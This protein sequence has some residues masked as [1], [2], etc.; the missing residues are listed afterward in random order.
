TF[1]QIAKPVGNDKHRLEVVYTINE[2][3]RVETA[4][5]VTV[6][7][8]STRQGLIDRTTQLRAG[9]PMR[10]DELLASESRLYNLGIFDWA[11]VD[12]RRQITTQNQEDVL[13]KLHEAKKNS[14]TYGFGFEV[15]N[16]GG[17]IPSGTV[18]L[19]NLPVVG[20]PANFKTSQQTFWGPRGTFEYTRKNV[21]GKAETF[22]IGGL[23]ARLDQRAN[24]TFTDPY[25]RG[26][27]WASTLNVSGEHNSENPIFTSRLV[28][29]SFQIQRPLNE[30]KTRTL[31]FRYTIK[32][33]GITH[34]L[35]PDL[36]PPE[37]QHVRLSTLSTSYIRDTRDN[38][39]DAHKGI[40]ESF[41]LDFNPHVLGSSVDFAKLLA[42][43]AYYKKIVGDTIFANSVRLGLE[44]PFAGSHVPLSEL[45]FSGGGST[46]RGF[47]LNGAGPQ[48]TVPACGNPADPSTCAKITVP[49]G[50]RQLFIVNSE[51]RVPIKADLPW[52]HQNLGVAAFYDGGNVYQS[53]GFH[54]FFS[55]FSN[56]IGLGLRY[57]TPVGPV[58]I[59]VGRNLNPVPGISSTQFFVTLGQAF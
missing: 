6:G 16:R 55:D 51:F 20:L 38:V 42:Q 14:L 48:R 45:F 31:F 29:A 59:D 24:I 21:R 53:I 56:T 39:L 10:E 30:D 18:A 22:T 25:F 41:Q 36:V 19:P 23:A 44:L 4:T 12:P 11:Q 5:I 34:L 13:V 3:P 35:I 17:N 26:S 57:R 47:P 50:G 2:G 52:V 33:T 49:V 27:N 32:Q 54:T 7:R 46:L 8:K 1:R 58:R 9:G 37:D 28:N 15:I 43:A 40:L